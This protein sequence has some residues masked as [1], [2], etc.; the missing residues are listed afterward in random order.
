MTV[1]RDPPPPS[2]DIEAWR[3]AVAQGYHRGY[4]L[5]V[6]VAALQDLGP[7][8]DKRVREALASRLSDAIMGLLRK[9]VGPN[10]PNQGWDIIE[11]AHTELLTSLLNPGS[12][13]GTMMRKAL[14]TLVE[15]RVKDAIASEFKH[16]RIPTTRVA[17]SADPEA[18]VLGTSGR[19]AESDKSEHGDQDLADEELDGSDES[20]RGRCL[21]SRTELGDDDE[22]ND[23]GYTS[24]VIR[25]P[26]LMDGVRDIDE[27]L[28]VNRILSTIKDPRKRLAFY[29]YM[30]VPIH[31]TKGNSIAAA[32]GVDRKTVKMWISEVKDQLSQLKEVN[33]LDSAASGGRQ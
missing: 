22:E 4:K 27:S 28:D 23:A 8:A 19:K 14:V 11:R 24:G 13:D 3:E 9:R 6:L 16:S 7:S 26:S 25:D 18:K 2:R 12:A 29:L 1:S 15:Y 20:F 31:S 10:H 17:K 32:L 33:L 21:P 5:E 30:D